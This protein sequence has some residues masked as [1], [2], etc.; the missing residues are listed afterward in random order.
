M[1]TNTLIDKSLRV[2]GIF[3]SV[4]QVQLNGEPEGNEFKTFRGCQKLPE[5]KQNRINTG[6]HFSDA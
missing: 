2:N 3:F 6:L 5:E 1:K 4:L